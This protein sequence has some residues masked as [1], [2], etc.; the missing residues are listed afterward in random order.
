M[1]GRYIC[2]MGKTTHIIEVYMSKKRRGHWGYRMKTL[3]GEVTS[4][5]EARFPTADDAMTYINDNFAP[6]IRK[7][8]YII[9]QTS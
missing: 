8:S 5:C 1:A 6:G 3:K 4:R 9:T 7:G 2:G